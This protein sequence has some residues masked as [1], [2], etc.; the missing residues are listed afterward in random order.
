MPVR[1]NLC[2]QVEVSFYFCESLRFRHHAVEIFPILAV[3]NFCREFCKLLQRQ[4]ACS[5]R[6]FFG[7]TNLHASA[8]VQTI[9]KR[10]GVKIGCPEEASFRAG[11]LSL[12][13]LAE[14]TAKIPNCE[15]REYLDGVVLEAKRLTKVK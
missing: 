12:E 9:E 14:L 10:A 8:Y 1:C 2:R 6:G 11:T 4:R 13:Q 7:T 5:E 15:Y 3:G